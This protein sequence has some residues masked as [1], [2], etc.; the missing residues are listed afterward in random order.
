MTCQL[1][2]DMCFDNDESQ[3]GNVDKFVKVQKS[4]RR[5]E[6]IN[7]TSYISGLIKI[8]TEVSLIIFL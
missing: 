2:K 1:G 3:N 6:Q 8:V 5:F 4:E 7:C